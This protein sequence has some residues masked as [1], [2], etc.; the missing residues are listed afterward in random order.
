MSRPVCYLPELGGCKWL[1]FIFRIHVLSGIC[2]QVDYIIAGISRSQIGNEMS[3]IGPIA[4]QFVVGHLSLICHM[5]GSIQEILEVTLEFPQYTSE[6]NAFDPQSIIVLQEQL[7]LLTA[8]KDRIATIH[9][10]TSQSDV[11]ILLLGESKES[12]ASICS[13]HAS[14][15]N[16]TCS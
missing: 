11:P 5:C 1:I 15:M 14:K 10:R 2:D 8:R 6:T 9:E 13:R 3:M 7:K 16:E 4:H 12:F